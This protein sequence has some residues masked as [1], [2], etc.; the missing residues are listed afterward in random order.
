MNKFEKELLKRIEQLES[1]IGVRRE[2]GD[3]RELRASQKLPRLPANKDSCVQNKKKESGVQDK[4]KES[5]VQDKKKESGV[6]DK[7]KESGVQEQTVDT[8]KKN[9][10]TGQQIQYQL[11]P[12]C[13]MVS[14]F[15]SITTVYAVPPHLQQNLVYSVPPTDSIV[16]VEI[17]HAGVVPIENTFPI[18]FEVKRYNKIDEES[19]KYENQ[20]Y[21][22]LFIPANPPFY[23]AVDMY[24]ELFPCET[25]IGGNYTVENLLRNIGVYNAENESDLKWGEIDAECRELFIV[26]GGVTDWECIKDGKIY[27]TEKEFKKV[28]KCTQMDLKGIE[29][30]LNGYITMRKFQLVKELYNKQS[31]HGYC[32]D[33]SIL[34]WI[35][36]EVDVCFDLTVYD[37]SSDRQA[38]QIT[39]IDSGSV[40]EF[41]KTQLWVYYDKEIFE[42]KTKKMELRYGNCKTAQMLELLNPGKKLEGW[43]SRFCEIVQIPRVGYCWFQRSC[44]MT[45]DLKRDFKVLR[46]EIEVVRDTMAACWLRDNGEPYQGSIYLRE[47][48]LPK[49]ME[50]DNVIDLDKDDE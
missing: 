2:A 13:Q 28:I 23:M 49:E 17:E 12:N 44:E 10:I 5:G 26:K 37:G 47:E 14:S 40:E 42:T 7:K 27:P 39:S 18:D 4:K 9:N 34:L 20:E 25:S 3:G 19:L 29:E 1:I 41:M 6:Q 36:E 45:G 22:E 33:P 50:E 11:F 43:D 48:D 35:L 21:R 46:N 31:E 32:L 15:N 8:V 30:E 38:R 16:A 24:K